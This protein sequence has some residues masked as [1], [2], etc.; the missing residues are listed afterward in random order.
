M[1]VQ[2]PFRN[3]TSGTPFRSAT[4]ST[5][6]M[7]ALKATNQ[8]SSGIVAPA[9]DATPFIASGGW[10]AD[11]GRLH[12]LLAAGAAIADGIEEN[13]CWWSRNLLDE[14]P[15][16]DPTQHI[17]ALEIDRGC[18]PSGTAEV[19]LFI[20]LLGGNPGVG[21]DGIGCVWS[22]GSLTADNIGQINP[23]T[24]TFVGGG[25]NME[26]VRLYVSLTPVSGTSYELRAF[27]R[28]IRQDLTEDSG[29]AT[30]GEISTIPSLDLSTYKIVWGLMSRSTDNKAAVAV[31]GVRFLTGL[32][33]IPSVM[34]PEAPARGT[35]AATSGAIN[36]CVFGDSI[37][38]GVGGAGQSGSGAVLPAYV[39]LW[40]DGVSQTNWPT[41]PGFMYQLA[42]D[43][44]TQGYTTIRFF[45]RAVTSQYIEV[46]VG[47]YLSESISACYDNGYTPDLV[48]TV[49]GTNDGNNTRSQ[50]QVDNFPL[51]LLNAMRR[52]EWAS[53][54]ARWIHLSP[55]AAVATHPY[56]DEIRTHIQTAIG[57]K[58]WR[59]YVD[60]SDL[61]RADNSHPTAA[62]YNTMGTRAAAKW[63]LLS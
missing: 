12:C 19:T 35:K 5:F 32:C 44:H 6:E 31:S 43:L 15:T 14:H 45:Q 39:N 9:A 26:G 56:I 61:A 27:G 55:L 49:I 33:S 36:V 34:R 1:S 21:Q 17:L 48:I 18:I 22:Q 29:P 38:D 63:A 25:D 52:A 4:G 23:T 57:G 8:G 3:T 30:W 40:V 7:V 10:D 2:G 37:S 24:L 54:K 51:Q 13:I 16:F 50:A 47:Q 60:C 41:D 53:L 59:G 42:E 11:Y 62:S 46:T 20:A 58:A 28:G